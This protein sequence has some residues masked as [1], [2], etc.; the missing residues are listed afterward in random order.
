MI[1]YTPTQT[2]S[3]DA[4][5]S[6]GA[7]SRTISGIAVEFNV[8]AT[9]NDGQQVLFKPGSLPVDG[10]N[11][12]L[13]LQHDPMK[14]IGQ[15]TE[16]LSTDEAML[17]TAKISATDLGNESLVLM[18]DGTLSE[19]SVGV[20][21]QKFSYDKNGVMVIEQASFNELSVVSQ[22]AFSGA[23]ITD[24]A[25]SIPQT[26]PEIELNK[27]IPT[28]EKPIMEESAVV[29]ASATVE[30][31]W[32]KPRQEFKMPTA[33]Q[34]LSAYVN[35]STKFAEYREGIKAAAR[36][37]FRKF[38][39]PM[40]QAPS[41]QLFAG[42][43]GKRRLEIGDWGFQRS[44]S[45]ALHQ[46]L[47]FLGFSDALVFVGLALEAAQFKGDE[48]VG[49]G[50]HFGGGGFGFG[51]Q[52]VLGFD[53]GVVVGRQ[54]FEGTAFGG[55]FVHVAEQVGGGK[56]DLPSAGAEAEVLDLLDGTDAKEGITA[57][58]RVVEK[59]EWSVFHHRNEP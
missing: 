16:R 58:E 47:H 27:D 54:V 8:V 13:Y 12:K 14:I 7:A 45:L 49:E 18:S 56:G 57:L 9:V 34:Y 35:N 40:E 22:P 20:D 39:C 59:S 30:K 50:F 52:A 48:A 38:H 32:A 11:P 29:E 26:E 42:V 46:Q 33:A 21:V 19:V 43:G 31:L 28:Q 37:H 51:V 23:V 4:A 25:A 15:V 17:F 5:A 41:A 24:V 1:R 2:I 44:I 10:R 3:V 36:E 6:D 55:G 53:L